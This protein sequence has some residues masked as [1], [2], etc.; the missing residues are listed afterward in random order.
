MSSSKKEDVNTAEQQQQSAAKKKERRSRNPMSSR[1][2]VSAATAGGGGRGGNGGV[3]SSTLL[4]FGLF[5]HESAGELARLTPAA[6]L[7]D[8]SALDGDDDIEGGEDFDVEGEGSARRWQGPDRSDEEQPEAVEAAHSFGV[9]G[10][11]HSAARVDPSPVPALPR[12]VPPADRHQQQQELEGRRSRRSSSWRASGAPKC[13]IASRQACVSD[14]TARWPAPHP[15]TAPPLTLLPPLFGL[16]DVSPSASSKLQRSPRASSRDSPRS[17]SS[18]SSSSSK[19]NQERRQRL[20]G[21]VPGVLHGI[22]AAAAA[23]AAAA[24]HS[25]LGWARARRR[26]QS[27]KLIRLAVFHGR[28]PQRVANRPRLANRPHPLDIIGGGR[29]KCLIVSPSQDLTEGVT[30]T[31]GARITKPIVEHSS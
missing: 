17:S 4:L 14:D 8:S 24:M 25:E 13:A 30:V 3:A 28:D 9:N 27:A 26:R 5:S 21:A 2:R 31:C 18:S 7:V 15:L 11:S 23:A 12:L 6:S 16:G 10:V 29:W 20:S 22:A 19:T 1:A